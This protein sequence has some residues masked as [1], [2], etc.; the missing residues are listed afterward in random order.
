MKN[1]SEHTPR[2]RSGFERYRPQV[3]FHPKKS[4][5][6]QISYHPYEQVSNLTSLSPLITGLSG[7]LWSNFSPG[8]VSEWLW[9]QC[10]ADSGMSVRVGV[11]SAIVVFP[12]PLCP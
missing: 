8:E 12:V 5:H 6:V 9:N 1:A 4:G 10:P 7:I 2:G 11:D 3:P